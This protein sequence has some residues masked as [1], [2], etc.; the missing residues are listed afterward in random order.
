MPLS[1][2]SHFKGVF[3]GSCPEVSLLWQNSESLSSRASFLHSLDSTDR[4]LISLFSCKQGRLQFRMFCLAQKRQMIVIIP[5][6]Y[7][8][9]L[10]P[11]DLT[12]R[13]VLSGNTNTWCVICGLSPECSLDAGVLLH[14][15][16]WWKHRHPESRAFMRWKRQ[17]NN[18]GL[19]ALRNVLLADAIH[20]GMHLSCDDATDVGRV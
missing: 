12:R 10:R 5:I 14:C 11:F 17:E 8:A 6:S 7:I 13:Q 18:P 4:K 15:A 20:F 19:Q 9:H 1:G 16:Q 3:I 2:S